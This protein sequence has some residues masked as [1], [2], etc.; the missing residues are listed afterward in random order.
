MT[1]TIFLLLVSTCI[2][3][4]LWLA[5][6]KNKAPELSVGNDTL[7]FS[8]T[9]VGTS[10]TGEIKLT[11]TGEED[12]VISS[13]SVE[14]D[15]DECFFVSG[16][17]STIAAGTECQM[18]LTFEPEGCGAKT[19]D[20]VIKSNAK[21][22]PEYTIT[23]SGIA[24]PQ[25]GRWE[26]TDVWF[27]VSEDG[28]SLTPEGS[29]LEEGASLIVSVSGIGCGGYITMT[30]YYLSEIPVVNSGFS[31]ISSDDNITGTFTD[32]NVCNVSGSMDG[33]FYYPS[34]CH[35]TLYASSLHATPSGD[36]ST[37]S[38][39]MPDGTYIEYYPD[40]RIRTRI[41]IAGN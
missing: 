39:S 17:Y 35:F 30:R 18:E 19:A 2:S 14:G 31:F 21:T 5:C 32:D 15:D 40:G 41:D 11:N 1:K 26:G 6:E 12:L 36:K 13:A 28:T 38:A 33:A 23:L 27:Y 3:A 4:M 20:L 7:V 25:P 29:P 9:C 22:N 8:S 16:K 10:V 24:L 34:V 37:H